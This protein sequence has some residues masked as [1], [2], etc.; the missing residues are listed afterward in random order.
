MGVAP[1]SELA[2]PGHLLVRSAGGRSILLTRSGESI[3]GFLNSCRH[4]GTEFAEAD[5]EV[6]KTIRCPYHRWT[7]S[8]D[9]RLVAAPLFDS[10][11]RGDFDRA[12]WGLVPVRTKTWGP[13]VFVS[14]DESTPPLAEWLGDLAIRMAGYGLEEWRPITLPAPP[15]SGGAAVAT[16][17]CTFDVAANWKLIAETFAEYYHLGWVHPE[18]AKVS[19]VKDHYRYQGPGM[20]CGQTT[21]PVSGDQRDDSGGRRIGLYDTS[22]G[23]LAGDASPEA[24]GGFIEMR[25]VVNAGGLWAREVGRMVGVERPVL[26]MEH[27]YVLTETV[28]GGATANQSPAGKRFVI[29]GAGLAERYYERWFDDALAAW[30]SRPGAGRRDVGGRDVGEGVLEGGRPSS[31]TTSNRSIPCDTPLTGSA[32]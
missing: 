13:I 11:P 3:R 31:K 22:G 5:C 32:S 21:T 1:A 24:D 25:H 4:R 2:R 14:L 10:L 30:M 19:R 12:D 23:H 26:A 27:M 20:Y 6:G 16:S 7:Y 28:T 17:S 15:D 9:S 18:L 8:T 29:F